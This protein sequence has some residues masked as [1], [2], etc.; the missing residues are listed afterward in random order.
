MQ[1]K[2]LN[3][4]PITEALLDIRVGVSEEFDATKFESLHSQV[5]KEFPVKQVNTQ[6]ETQFELKPGQEPHVKSKDSPNG[7]IFKTSTGER[8]FQARKDGFT[9]NSV[10]KYS[11]WA[12]FSSDARRLWNLYAPVA[13]PLSVKRIAL[14]FINL[15]PIPKPFGDFKEYMTIVPEISPNLPQGLSEYF[16]RLVL[17]DNKSKNT[18]IVIETVDTSKQTE[19]VFPLIFDLDVFR[20]FVDKSPSEDEMWK[21]FEEIREYKNRIFFE[22]FTQKAI[23]LFS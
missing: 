15:I 4:P 16:M 8:I 5:T 7:F 3:N 1:I 18:A 21:A 17:P 12:S 20:V 6:W 9:F 22:N 2:T 10:G 23:K 19:K 14:R 13:S 11:G